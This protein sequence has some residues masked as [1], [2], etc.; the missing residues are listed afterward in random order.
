MSVTHEHVGDL[1]SQSPAFAFDK[2]IV[3]KKKVMLEGLPDRTPEH[4]KYR[5]T[6]TK[7]D[8]K[9]GENYG[10]ASERNETLQLVW[11][12]SLVSTHIARRVSST[13]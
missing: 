12:T 4:T 1:S 5:F 8:P 3:G 7:Y 11:L 10:F 9:I 13:E 2:C 6:G